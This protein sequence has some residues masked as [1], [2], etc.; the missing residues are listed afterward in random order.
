MLSYKT[1]CTTSSLSD[2]QTKK[3]W[4]QE[5]HKRSIKCIK[6]LKLTKWLFKRWSIGSVTLLSSRSTR[7]WKKF[8]KWSL[9]LKLSGCKHQHTQVSTSRTSW[10]PD[11]SF[12]RP[13]PN[14]LTLRSDHMTS[15]QKWSWLETQINCKN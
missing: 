1:Q 11:C 12:W 8:R 15:P 5:F 14:L 9:M 4:R 3:S 13:Y 7:H 2:C 10:K 6:I